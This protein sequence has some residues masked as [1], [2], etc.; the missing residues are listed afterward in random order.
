ME[1]CDAFYVY[2]IIL[3]LCVSLM[4]FCIADFWVDTFTLLLD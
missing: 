2:G 1:L 3:V 4:V